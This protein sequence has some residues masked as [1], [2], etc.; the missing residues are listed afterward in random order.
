MPEAPLDEAQDDATLVAIRDHGARRR[1]HRHRR[2]DPPRELL[3][4]LRDRAR[5]ASTSTTPARH[6]TA[7]A[8]PIRS[9][10]SSARSAARAPSRCATSS[11]CGAHTDRPIKI[12]VPGPFTMSQQ[13]QNDYYPDGRK[14][15]LDYAAA[16]NEELRDVAAAGADIVQIDEPYLQARAEA[17]REYALEAIARALEGIDARDRAAHLLRLRRDRPLPP[18]RLLLPRRAG[19]LR[20]R[21]DLDR[22]GAAAPRPVGAGAAAVARRIVLGVLDLD[23][24]HVETAGSRRRANPRRADARAAGAA[25]RRAGLRDEVPPARRRPRQVTR[26]G[27]RRRTRPPRALE[28]ALARAAASVSPPLGYSDRPTPESYRHPNGWLNSVIM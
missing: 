16:V 11:S 2:R 8:T 28:A 5:R 3:E 24:P 18:G 25:A 15:A 22:G 10:A 27:R 6:S 12:T 21:P 20:R 23:D 9:R 1:R 14:L 17:A 13:A 7:P 26:A 19:R 4:P